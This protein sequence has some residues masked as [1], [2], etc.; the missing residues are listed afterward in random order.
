M[1][2]AVIE[3]CGLVCAA[4]YIARVT[5]FILLFPVEQRDA[6]IAEFRQRGVLTDAEADLLAEFFD[7][8]VS[9]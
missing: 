4:D 1:G 7:D 2:G 9:S 8:P 5:S 6:W 3:V